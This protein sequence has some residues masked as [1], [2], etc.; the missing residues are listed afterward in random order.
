MSLSSKGEKIMS[1]YSQHNQG[2]GGKGIVVGLLL[3]GLFVA[4][5]A[6]LGANG[7]EVEPGTAVIDPATPVAE[8]ETAPAITE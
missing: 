7:S 1:D 8:P 4:G 5:L 2:I 6:F 3:I